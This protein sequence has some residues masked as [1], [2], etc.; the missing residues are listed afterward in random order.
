[1]R[2]FLRWFMGGDVTARLAVA[3]LSS[4]K[5][6]ALEEMEPAM[7]VGGLE[8]GAG[9]SASSL[10]ETDCMSCLSKPALAAA[11]I[12]GLRGLEVGLWR[13]PFLECWIPC[14]IEVWR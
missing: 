4:G 1:M 2:S 13:L 12:C 7:A 10:S 3:D 6:L 11:I 14:T 5:L 8:P 9:V